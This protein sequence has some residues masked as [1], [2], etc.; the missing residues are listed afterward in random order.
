VTSFS[1]GARSAAF[2]RRR[3]RPTS[4]G[5]ASTVQHYYFLFHH[6]HFSPPSTPLS[7]PLRVRQLIKF[8]CLGCQWLVE[9]QSVG[10]DWNV[11]QRLWLL[12]SFLTA[13]EYYFNS[14][15]KN[16]CCC[17]YT[18]TT[19]SRLYCLTGAVCCR[20]RGSHAVSDV[21]IYVV[22][23]RHLRTTARQTGRAARRHLSSVVGEHMTKS[24]IS[25]TIID[26]PQKPQLIRS[27]I[28][29]VFMSV[30]F[31]KTANLKLQIP[32]LGKIS[33]QN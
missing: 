7:A 25:Q 16:Y 13:A 21:I 28:G 31:A 33:G 10:N 3:L 12:C 22:A 8:L 1:S 32:H 29:V 18:T 5:G 26:T 15:N 30:H 9:G 24:P 27:V 17:C 14:N 11:N 19:T 20:R 6:V 23:F 4:S 2:Y